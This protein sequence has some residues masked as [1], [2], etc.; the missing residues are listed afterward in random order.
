M[1]SLI[2]KEAEPGGSGVLVHRV[3]ARLNIGGPAIHV[4]NLSEGLG[5]TGEFVTRL[6]AGRISPDEGDMRYYAR[7]RGVEVLEVPAISRRVDPLKDVWALW[8]LYRVFRRERPQI[9][10]THTAKAGTLGRLAA[11]LAGVPIRIHTFHGHVL[12]GAYFSPWLTRVYL[13]I[14]RQ[15]ARVSQRLV[16]LTE[17]QKRE[18]SE[19]KRIA[20]PDRF[21]V[22]PLG[23]ELRRFTEVDREAVRRRTRESL[24][25]GQKE[26]VV[27]TVGRLVPV[28][29]HRLLLAAHP[30]LE[31]LMGR[32]VRL[33][34]VGSG[35]LEG[36]LRRLG[37]ALGTADRV[38]WLGW[39]DDLH[40]LYPALDAFALTSMDEGTP[41][42]VIEAL[43]SGT[44]V[45]ARAV[46]GVPEMLAGVPL[47]RLIPHGDPGSVAEGLM[48]V[49]RIMLPGPI[50]EKVRREIEARYAVE[51]LLDRV[52]DL[53]RSELGRAG[54]SG[55]DGL[56]QTLGGVSEVGSKNDRPER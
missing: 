26:V 13:G 49:S 52:S 44:P 51:G 53:Y 50:L 6:I 28:K 2:R 8:S 35:A 36:E 9:V 12:G 40:L 46:G 21:A 54:L 19:E 27:G 47:A 42:A 17:G 39:R 10:H 24:G 33:I 16:V 38:L 15:L 45:A 23:L 14:E 37:E 4:V 11:F 32:P 41:V 7:E 55:S 5:R 56:P 25:I 3:I 31:T 20:G 30:L 34:V 43:A 1:P 18:L 22:I 48:E 29:N